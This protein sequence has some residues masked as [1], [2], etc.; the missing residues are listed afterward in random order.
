VVS[1]D[2]SG[3]LRTDSSAVLTMFT[4]F[5]GAA[6]LSCL[7]C[8]AEYKLFWFA[9]SWALTYAFALHYGLFC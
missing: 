1:E 7:V 3:F 5:F 2:S 4:A 8:S 9:S 6:V